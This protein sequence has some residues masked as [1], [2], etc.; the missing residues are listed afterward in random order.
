MTVTLT[1]LLSI[2]VLGTPLALANEIPSKKEL[3]LSRIASLE[4]SSI[5]G[6][7]DYYDFEE[8][9]ASL[10]DHRE[11]VALCGHKFAVNNCGLA[12][13]KLSLLEQA[14]QN[15][16]DLFE[17]LVQMQQINSQLAIP[18]KQPWQDPPVLAQ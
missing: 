7:V 3:L 6:D 5:G 18:T 17:D 10:V 8:V 11:Y 12:I 16:M 13:K 9:T 4:N 15:H 2:V 14:Y 1:W